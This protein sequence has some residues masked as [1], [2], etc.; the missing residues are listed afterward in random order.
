MDGFQELLI[1]V[2]VNACVLGAGIFLIY[3]LNRAVSACGR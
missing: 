1:V 2:A 3:R